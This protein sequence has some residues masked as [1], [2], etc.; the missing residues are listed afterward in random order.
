MDDTTYDIEGFSFSA[1][2]AGIKSQAEPRLDFALIASDDPCTIAGIT[3]TN[4]VYA[5]PVHLTRERLQGG[6]CKA[7]LVNS[8]NANA[9]TGEK[10]IDDAARL[11]GEAGAQLGVDPDLVIPLSTGVIGARLPVERMVVVIPGLVK[12]LARGRAEDVARAIMTTDTVP[13]LSRV[14]RPS[15]S[16][17][18]S[19]V[20]IA[21]G[22]GMIAPNMATM[23]AVVV[24][25]IA[26]D[27][28][29]LQQALERANAE[30][31]GCI[32]IDGDMS[33]ND[34]LL[35]LSGGRTD[36]P[37]LS[38]TSEDRDEFES[39]LTE[40]CDDLA[41]KIVLDGEGTTKLVEINVVGAS[42]KAYAVKIA[43]TIAE[44]PLVK[45]AFCGEDPNWGRIVAA[46]GRAGV[47]FDPNRIDLFIGDVPVMVDGAI[48]E[49][50]WETPAHQI[51][52]QQSFSIMVD[53]KSGD[54]GARI[55][56]TDL[57]EEYVRINAD[58]RT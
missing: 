50:D 58:Y 26:V 41:R 23:L 15:A 32:T 5:A 52:K 51:M 24:T 8:G 25:D 45:T 43:R 44:S 18:F 17:P 48:V 13:K 40:V 56:T 54:A 39:A 27:R 28:E 2:S 35:V 49:G 46:A 42:R 36:A 37:Q 31:F 4:L 21:K 22:A 57:T 9:C 12:G 47:P 16:V 38:E 30:T 10:G 53:I 11:T 6:R 14:D 19:M 3:T 29:F 20:G 1:V 33:T 34:T 55:L 7:V